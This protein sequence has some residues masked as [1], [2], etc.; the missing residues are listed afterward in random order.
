[1]VRLGLSRWGLP[2]AICPWR[3]STYYRCDVE[4]KENFTLEVQ[5]LKAQLL[6][7]TTFPKALA[8]RNGKICRTWTC[9]EIGSVSS[10]QFEITWRSSR[11]LRHDKVISDFFWKCIRHVTY[12]VIGNPI[13]RPKVTSTECLIVQRP[14]WHVRNLGCDV[15]SKLSS[16]RTILDKSKNY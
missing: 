6:G 7:G 4:F 16:K 15:R 11:P 1:M 10:E 2:E 5:H 9:Y 12:F 14:I 8:R 13:L 3:T